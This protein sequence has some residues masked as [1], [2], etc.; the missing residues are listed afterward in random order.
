MSIEVVKSQISRFLCSDKPEVLAIKGAW[1]VG[2]TSSWNKFLQNA[3]NENSIALKKYSYVSLFGINSLDAFKYSIFEHVIN[4]NMIGTEASVETFKE[5]TTGLLEAMGRKS[6]GLFKGTSL[7]K[8]FTPAIESLSFL[9]LNSS[10]ICIDDL[11]RRGTN[12]SMKD[13]LGLVTQLKEQKKC[14]I[15]LLLNDKEEGLEDYKKYREKVIDTE[16]KFSPTAK[17]CSEM[18]FNIDNPDTKRLLDFTQELDIKNIRV[19]KN[20]KG[21]KPFKEQPDSGIL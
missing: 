12:L 13:V 9:S 7:L 15:V 11:E 3:K 2:K 6:I 19:L 21:S 17:E 16:L 4:R 5:N 10:L 18:A 1:G 14:K 20:L 8:S